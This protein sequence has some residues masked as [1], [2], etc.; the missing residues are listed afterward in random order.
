M[1]VDPPHVIVFANTEPDY[2]KLSKDRWSIID[3]NNYEET[4]EW[5]RL[6]RFY[7]PN[8]KFSNFIQ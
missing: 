2:A 7:K 3:L 8:I 6:K 5:K 1:I 4:L